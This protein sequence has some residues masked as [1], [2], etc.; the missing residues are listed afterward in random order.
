MTMK[1][2][3]SCII[4]IGCLTGILLCGCREKT[5]STVSTTQP[6]TTS[7]DFI[8]TTPPTEISTETIVID[9]ASTEIPTELSSVDINKTNSKIKIT[10]GSYT[11]SVSQGGEAF[12]EMTAS[13]STEYLAAVLD[14]NDSTVNVQNITSDENGNLVWKWNVVTDFPTGDYTVKIQGDSKHTSFSISVVE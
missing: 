13:P 2:S 5:V 8:S 10:L 6:S 14:N 1:K 12:A 11:N 9:T 7:A 4:L 3:I